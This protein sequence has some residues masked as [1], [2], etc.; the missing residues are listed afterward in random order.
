MSALLRWGKFNLVGAMG[1]AVQLAALWL[2]NRLLH[3]HYLWASALAVECTLLHNFVW[4][5]HFTWRDRCDSGSRRRQCVR[6]HLSAGVVSLLGGVV[7]MHLLVQG[8]HLPL[9]PANL[10]AILCCSLVNFWV[11][12]GWAFAA[13]RGGTTR[14]SE[15]AL[16][17]CDSCGVGAVGGA[18]FGDG[19][20]EVVAHGA[21]GES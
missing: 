10:V 8:A 1:M 16:G 4:H 18:E 6:F 7:L 21:F 11:G 12:N 14:A 5:V 15:P 13:T 17:A 3:G 9:L 20:G 2:L 19:L